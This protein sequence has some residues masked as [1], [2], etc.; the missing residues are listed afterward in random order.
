MILYH[1]LQKKISHICKLC[2]NY[3][4]QKIFLVDSNTKSGTIFL[5]ELTENSKYKLLS[6]NPRIDFILTYSCSQT[7]IFGFF[8][9][10][11]ELK[12]VKL[13][14]GNNGHQYDWAPQLF[15]TPVCLKTEELYH[16][17]VLTLG[18]NNIYTVG[19]V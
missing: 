7:V 1:L 4:S 11:S 13:V 12:F 10:E 14:K 19:C 16:A 17:Y 18:N 9:F 5:A 6:A 8:P 2:K 3:T 15:S